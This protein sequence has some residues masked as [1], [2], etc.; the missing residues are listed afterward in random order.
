M[1][2]MFWDK[3]NLLNYFQIYFVWWIA[4]D[5]FDLDFVRVGVLKVEDSICEF[6]ANLIINR[7]SLI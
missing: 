5:E 2:E 7:L 1:N 3:I 4:D 6:S